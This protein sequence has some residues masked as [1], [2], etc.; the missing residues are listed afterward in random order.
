MGMKM[1]V[2]PPAMQH[3][4]EAEFHPQTFRIA[5]NGEQGF[6]G[7]AE[8]DIVDDLFVVEG[9]GCDGLGLFHAIPALWEFHKVHH[10]AEVLTPL[11][12]MRTHPVEIIAFMNII[13]LFT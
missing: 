8:E 7:G 10:S 5:G 13:G 2:L 9:D 3:C 4:E 11:T 12:E 1:Q 6:G